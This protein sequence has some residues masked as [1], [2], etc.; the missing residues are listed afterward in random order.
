MIKWPT[1]AHRQHGFSL[2]ELAIALIVIGLMASSMLRSNTGLRQAD[3]EKRVERQL[4]QAIDT[5]YGH[6]IANGRLPCPAAPTLPDSTA[7]AG[8]EDCSL[9]HGVLPW[10][11]LGL[12][13]TDPWGQRL[14]YYA[15]ESFSA[16][17][18]TDARASFQLE[19][20]GNATI[21]PAST[22][23]TKLADTLPAVVLSHGANGEGGYRPDGT[24][25]AAVAGDEA[26]NAD[27]DLTFISRPP[28]PDFDDRIDWIVPGVLMS[29]MLSAGRLP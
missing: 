20:K 25:V 6:A 21:K 9:K 27:A 14:S 3:D 4:A 24:R 29:R 23:S 13:Q 15:H 5:L 10:I 17:L 22:V 16:P 2:I 12:T 19:S 11:T 26:E 7:N 28:G 18:P 8:T 1:K